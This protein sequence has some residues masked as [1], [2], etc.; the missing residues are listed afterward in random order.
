MMDARP[1]YLGM[2]PMGFLDRCECGYVAEDISEK[3]DVTNEDIESPEYQNIVR[4]DSIVNRYAAMA[5]LHSSKG[6]HSQS[7]YAYL[8]GAWMADDLGDEDSSKQMRR[9]YLEETSNIDCKV[10]DNMVRA[11]VLRCLGMFEQAEEAIGL[12]QKKNKDRGFDF[13]IDKEKALI[14]DSNPHPSD[15]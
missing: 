1:I 9:K 2:D 6:R 11:D 12:A 10:E 13:I 4:E 8:R 5:F 3:T 7:A 14:S 15:C